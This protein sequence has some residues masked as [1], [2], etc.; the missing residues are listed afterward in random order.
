VNEPDRFRLEHIVDQIDRIVRYTA[1]GRASFETDELTQDAVLRCLTVLGE[2]AN[3]LGP[4]T[5]KL[6]ESLPPQLPKRQRNLI[7]H[8]YR[9]IDLGILWA[10][11]QMICRRCDQRS[12]L[13]STNSEAVGNMVAVSRHTY[14]MWYHIW[15]DQKDHNISPRR[16]QASS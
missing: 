16:T 10:P 8:E 6:I 11:S 3:A 14:R 5:Y 2:A 15:H 1:G 9:R 7:V 12:R 13:S 4:D